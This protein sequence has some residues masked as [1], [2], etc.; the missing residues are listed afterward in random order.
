MT[1]CLAETDLRNL[2]ANFLTGGGIEANKRI[3][4]PGIQLAHLN[5][6]DAFNVFSENSPLDLH[7]VCI[8]VK[9]DTVEGQSHIEQDEKVYGTLKCCFNV[10]KLMGTQIDLPNFE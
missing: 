3:L 2:R 9:M 6:R 10:E 4:F 1:G 8:A 7:C 5:E